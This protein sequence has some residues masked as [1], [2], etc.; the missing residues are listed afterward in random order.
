MEHFTWNCFRF[1]SLIDFES[2]VFLLATWRMLWRFKDML[3]SRKVLER[4]IDCWI[5]S[6]ICS[7]L[8][9][10]FQLA[11]TPKQVVSYRSTINK[12]YQQEKLSSKSSWLSFIHST[13]LHKKSFVDTPINLNHSSPKLPSNMPHSNKGKFSARNETGKNYLHHLSMKYEPITIIINIH[14][15]AIIIKILI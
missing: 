6:K 3:M 12:A 9:F 15:R 2:E 10:D 1:V 4:F 8:F 14:S 5:I 7:K 11:Q 13:K